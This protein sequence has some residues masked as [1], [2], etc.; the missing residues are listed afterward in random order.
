MKLWSTI[1]WEIRIRISFKFDQHS[2]KRFPFSSTISSRRRK[3][4]EKVWDFFEF[5]IDHAEFVLKYSYCILSSS[6]LSGK[7]PYCIFLSSH[8]KF[9]LHTFIE[10]LMSQ[11]S[12]CFSSLN[13]VTIRKERKG[14]APNISRTNDDR[15]KWNLSSLCL[16]SSLS[17]NIKYISFRE[18][19]FCFKFVEPSL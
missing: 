11:N 2:C 3:I 5:K 12:C 13:K 7:N 17:I 15:I 6:R 9:L 19:K 1:S 8:R 14:K 18:K 4:S 16:H 10:S